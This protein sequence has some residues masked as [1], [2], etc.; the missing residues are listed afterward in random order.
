MLRSTVLTFFGAGPLLI[1]GAG[2]I[3]GAVSAYYT[4][5]PS[6]PWILFVY[7]PLG[8]LLFVAGAVLLV[9]AQNLYESE[10]KRPPLSRSSVET[11]F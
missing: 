3:L 6:S 2:M 9:R 8:T 4:S 10:K 1:G 7:V 11:E 5:V